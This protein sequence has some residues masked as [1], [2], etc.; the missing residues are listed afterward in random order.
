MSPGVQ[1][2]RE[3]QQNHVF[4]KQGVVSRSCHLPVSLSLES[5]MVALCLWNEEKV[6]L[7]LHGSKA[8][9]IGVEE[10][11]EFLTD[12]DRVCEVKG[13]T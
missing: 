4:K 5:G 8:L 7:C 6:V 9:E 2:Q 11:D 13:E 10:E 1:D 3:Q 12:D